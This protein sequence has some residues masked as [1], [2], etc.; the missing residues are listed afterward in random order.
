MSERAASP[1]E[2]EASER[3]HRR[4]ELLEGFCALAAQT[5]TLQAGA[6]AVAYLASRAFPTDPVEV[7]RL[8]LGVVPSRQTMA[9]L[10]ASEGELRD[11]GLADSR[12]AGRLVI[13]W[14]ERYGRVAT[15]SVRAI[16]ASDPWPKY[17]YLAGAPLPPF[18][19]VDHIRR[20]RS[21]HSLMVTEGPLDAL[22]V[23]VAGIDAVV[24]LGGSQ[25]G[26]RHMTLLQELGIDAVTLA[27]DND[28]AGSAATERFIDEARRTYPALRIQVVP[29]DAFGTAK[30]PSELIVTAGP[31]A[32][33][34]AISR[35]LPAMVH[36]ARVALGDL[37]PDSS[38]GIRRDGLAAVRV[39]VEEAVGPERAADVEDIVTLAVERLGYP[40]P[41]VRDALL[42]PRTPI[43]ARVDASRATGTPPAADRVP[44]FDPDGLVHPL[45]WDVC[46]GRVP[47]GAKP[48][49][50]ELMWRIVDDIDQRLARVISLHYGR[51]GPMTSLADIA[52]H[53][54]R[55]GQPTISRER[56]RQLRNKALTRLRHRRRF[57]P[58]FGLPPYV[59][60]GPKQRRPPQSP[61]P[62]SHVGVSAST[63]RS[64]GPPPDLGWL[65]WPEAPPKPGLPLRHGQRWSEREDEAL[66]LWAAHAD[67]ERSSGCSVAS[68]PVSPSGSSGWASPSSRARCR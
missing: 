46:K 31:D 27:L 63:P 28:D 67:L 54:T 3:S 40:E 6:A 45:L 18:F 68:A 38:T 44:T 30:D 53:V 19:G 49:D 5:L 13:P 9:R 35:R 14:R 33:Y 58:L 61:V 50:D 62:T 42:A 11:A 25:V 34:E 39:V 41:V 4:S 22:A 20:A 43:G 1:E 59:P 29:A 51:Y 12:W 64:S 24:A 60:A 37:T 36:R 7:A 8:G 65:V 48:I 66:M 23:R 21:V 26:S 17:L 15:V 16:D 57:G 56:V 55:H 10:N 32:I 2:R 52:P 47:S